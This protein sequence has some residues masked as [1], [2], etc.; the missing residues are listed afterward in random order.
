MP[1]VIITNVSGSQLFLPD[2]YV[3]L[4]AG[5]SISL[6]RTTP[7]LLAA[8]RLQELIADGSIEIESTP[9]AEELRNGL[10]SFGYPGLSENQEQVHLLPLSIAAGANA[11]IPGP[12]AGFVRFFDCFIYTPDTIGGAMSAVTTTFSGATVVPA[13]SGTTSTIWTNP[14]PLAPGESYLI[15][16]GGPNPITV[17]AY[18]WDERIE[19]RVHCR[20]ALISGAAYTTLI[21]AAPVGMIGRFVL[22][23]RWNGVASIAVLAHVSIFNADNVGHSLQLF[24]GAGTVLLGR[25]ASVAAGSNIT[26][27]G[28][29]LAHCDDTADLTARLSE[30]STTPVLFNGLYE[31]VAAPE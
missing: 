19:D 29:F 13:Q 30:A 8:S 31:Y 1:N 7:E 17:N 16:N 23:R 10:E 11:S 25:T 2:F 18:Y 14:F 4:P 9:T 26:A 12:P 22:A 3:D 15:N 27:T 20:G 5:Q 6:Y 21:P 24:R 28:L